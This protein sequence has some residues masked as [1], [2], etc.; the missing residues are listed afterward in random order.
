[1]IL[2]KKAPLKFKKL[3]QTDSISIIVIYI[4]PLHQRYIRYYSHFYLFYVISSSCLIIQWPNEFSKRLRQLVTFPEQFVGSSPSSKRETLLSRCSW[5][6]RWWFPVTRSHR[7][8]GFTWRGSICRSRGNVKVPGAISRWN[9][10]RA[11]NISNPTP[12]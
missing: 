5:K 4:S 8:R 6:L 9:A 11:S 10:I 1:M 2:K 7:K 12:P 3:N